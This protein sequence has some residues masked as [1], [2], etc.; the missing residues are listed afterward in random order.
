MQGPRP[1][2][3]GTDFGRQVASVLCQL[4]DTAASCALSRSAH[5]P[6]PPAAHY[7]HSAHSPRRMQRV[8]LKTGSHRLGE[9]ALPPGT[10][11]P[12]HRRLGGARPAEHSTSVITDVVPDAGHGGG[13]GG[14]A[15]VRAP[16]H[17][18]TRVQVITRVCAY[19]C[20]CVCAIM[21]SRSTRSRLVPQ[22]R[23]PAW[24]GPFVGGPL[25]VLRA[26]RRA[27]GL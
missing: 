22:S 19:M 17:V 13:P 4:P 14:A 15:G 23:R 25:I 21:G 7:L 9:T 24:D 12:P 18:G 1:C 6:G 2:A 16:E 10:R 8:G 5:P 26:S 27:G 20:K 3:V 11:A